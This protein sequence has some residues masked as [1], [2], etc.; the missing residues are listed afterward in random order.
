M[1]RMRQINR[2]LAPGLIFAILAASPAYA[3]FANTY[4]SPAAGPS[5]DAPKGK[6][7]DRPVPPGQ[8][9]RRGLTGNVVKIDGGL[10]TVGT[11]FGNVA[12]S[13]PVGFDMGT[14]SVGNRIAALLEKEEKPPVDV[15]PPGADT[16]TPFGPEVPE[17]T[18]DTPP[19][20]P[21]IPEVTTD[22]P[23][24]REAMAKRI[25]II[26]TQASLSHHRG[27][28]QGQDDNSI[29]V[30]DEDGDEDDLEVTG[31]GGVQTSPDDGTGDGSDGTGDGGD[32]TGVEQEQVEAGTDA[33]LLIECAGDKA[34]VRSIQRADRVAQRIDRLLVKAQERDVA[35]AA[36]LA[37]L[38]QKN[39]DRK[40]ARLDRTSQNAP[41]GAK[42]NI[43]KARGKGK[44]DCTEG[45][46]CPD[47]RG[48][49]DDKGQGG[50]DK[51]GGQGGGSDKGKGPPEDKGKGK[52]KS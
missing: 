39:E 18:T 13:P 44:N 31:D 2:L 14:L 50:G 42:G 51:G 15:G 47:D 3:A 41:P 8:L 5:C 34:T 11:K 26:P 6:K 22:T 17:G 38:Q 21:E 10:I 29:V 45:E 37:A 4:A 32:G 7:V 9:T 25:T 36:K 30:V 28:V 46:E 16:D 12:I 1:D 23:P 52:D 48:K 20:G 24:F 27:V 19:F 49:P 35:R 43:D 40:Q 33:I